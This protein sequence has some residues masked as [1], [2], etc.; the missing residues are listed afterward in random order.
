M[1]QKDLALGL[2][3]ALNRLKRSKAFAGNGHLRGA[4]KHILF[5]VD[6]LNSGKPV[7]PSEIATHLSVSMP[8]VTHQINS[9]EKQGLILR[10]HGRDDRRVVS[11]ELSPKGKKEVEALK[12]EF[13]AKIDKLISYLGEKDTQELIR[14]IKRISDLGQLK[15]DDA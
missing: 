11:I 10:V 12:K 7:T 3:D 5:Q 14:I 1:N 6:K 9:L 15:E 4:E 2:Q 8:A 13:A